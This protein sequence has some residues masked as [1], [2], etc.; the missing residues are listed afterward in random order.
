M[1][2]LANRQKGASKI[3]FFYLEIYLK[4]KHIEYY[5]NLYL[6]EVQIIVAFGVFMETE[7][8]APNKITIPTTKGSI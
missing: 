5:L 2:K 6:I 8:N 7:N 4:F 3:R 1:S